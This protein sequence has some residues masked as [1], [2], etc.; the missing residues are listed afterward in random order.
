MVP[1]S[2]A[3]DIL[4]L[5]YEWDWNNQGKPPMVRTWPLRA[6]VEE[7]SDAATLEFER[8][9]PL[10]EESPPEPRAGGHAGR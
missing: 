10:A 1:P 3:G 2:V 4:A 6:P 5:T 7:E 9:F 8:D